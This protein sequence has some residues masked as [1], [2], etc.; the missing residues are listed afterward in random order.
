MSY[1]VCV[2]LLRRFC[3]PFCDISN[4][5]ILGDGSKILVMGWI[6]RDKSYPM[7]CYSIRAIS[8]QT[9]EDVGGVKLD[10]PTFGIFVCGTKW[11]VNYPHD[12]GRDFGGPGVSDLEKFS[13]PH[14]LELVD[15]F[16]H[17]VKEVPGGAGFIDCLE[18]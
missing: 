15:W 13:D 18:I 6:L 1:L 16:D 11:N 4:L 3:P 10:W 2:Q 8:I 5:K 7:G 14:R 9:G 12:L 17:G